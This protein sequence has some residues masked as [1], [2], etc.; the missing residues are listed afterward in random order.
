MNSELRGAELL[1]SAACRSFRMIGHI[2]GLE[3]RADRD[4]G[5]AIG[6]V[7]EIVS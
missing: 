6:I 3:G 7:V 2:G 5:L 4:L 1:S